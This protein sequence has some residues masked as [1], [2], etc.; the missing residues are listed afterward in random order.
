MPPKQKPKSNTDFKQVWKQNFGH[1]DVEFQFDGRG[2]CLGMFTTTEIIARTCDIA[3][4]G[5][6]RPREG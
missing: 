1:Y 2:Y 5:F 3:A 6:D 4:W